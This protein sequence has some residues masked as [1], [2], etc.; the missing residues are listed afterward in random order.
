MRGSSTAFTTS[1]S[2]HQGAARNLDKANLPQFVRSSGAPQPV[3]Q[4]SVVVMI[5]AL[6]VEML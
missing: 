4:G 2:V 1:S 5:D 3:I 6:D